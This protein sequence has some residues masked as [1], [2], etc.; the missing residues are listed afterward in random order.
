M[1]PAVFPDG[2]A[3]SSS[4]VRLDVARQHHDSRINFALELG[5]FRYKLPGPVKFPFFRGPQRCGPREHTVMLT[6]QLH[7]VEDRDPAVLD[8]GLLDHVV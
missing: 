7:P 3:P 2:S 6:E 5:P 8:G 1:H 4:Q